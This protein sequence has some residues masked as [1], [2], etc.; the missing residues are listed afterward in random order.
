MRSAAEAL[1]G[2]LR[3]RILWILRLGTGRVEG[4]GGVRRVCLTRRKN[5]FDLL[6]RLTGQ[7][8]YNLAPVRRVG[9]W[10]G[11]GSLGRVDLSHGIQHA[12]TQFVVSE[13]DVGVT[14]GRRDILGGGGNYSTI[15]LQVPTV[16][17]RATRFREAGGC[18]GYG[19]NHYWVVIG[20]SMYRLEVDDFGG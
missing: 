16:P 9:G 5:V 10:G 11:K 20:R 3:C 7:L 17:E 2:E 6:F 14:F 18:P 15:E 1:Q 4:A 19:S 13:L 12:V 8:L